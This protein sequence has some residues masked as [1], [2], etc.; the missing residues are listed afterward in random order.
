MIP[1]VTYSTFVYGAGGHAKVVADALACAGEVVLGFVD[2]DPK[3]LAAPVLGLPVL[4]FESLPSGARVA[5][6]IGDNR[7]R[8]LL[9]D[10]CAA[11]GVS[12]VSAVH[13]SA[14]VAPSARVGHG[15]VILAGAVV[16]PDAV[17]GE[18]VIVNTAAIVEHDVIVGDYAHLSP[19]AILAGGSKLGAF[20]HLGLGATVLDDIFVGSETVIGANAVVNRHVADR[21]VAYGVPARVQRQ[22]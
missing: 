18:G 1:R 10:K 6:G 17:V 7:V 3:K 5:L 11:A 15:T 14:V 19:G 9:A 12:L 13:P 20:S 22:L 21:V 2:D 8:K 16:N 4:R